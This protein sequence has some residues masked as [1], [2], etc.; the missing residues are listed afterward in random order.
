M[1]SLTAALRSYTGRD[2]SPVPLRQPGAVAKALLAEVERLV[3]EMGQIE[4]DPNLHSLVS[5]L[6][7]AEA[8]MKARHPELEEDALATLAWSW[9][10]DWK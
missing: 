2:T 4:P 5:A 7:W 6:A 3:N 9:S 8:E 10:Y 1:N